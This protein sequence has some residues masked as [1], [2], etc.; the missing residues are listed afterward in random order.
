MASRQ[1]RNERKQLKRQ[2]NKRLK[3][4]KEQEHKRLEKQEELDPLIG[5][6]ATTGTT[7]LCKGTACI[8]A[9]SKEQMARFV[10]DT[11]EEDRGLFRI[12]P[13]RF[14]HIASVYMVGDAYA[15]DET[16]YRRFY[17]LG[18]I[19]GLP[20]PKPHFSNTDPSQVELMTLFRQDLPREW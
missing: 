15:F 12:E 16:A 14:S 1:K 20:L 6:V 8:V 19:M 3:K 4:L 9:G 18:R 2:E 13:A 7:M 5:Y 11:S 10:Q 17:E